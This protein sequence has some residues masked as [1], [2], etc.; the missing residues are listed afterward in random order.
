MRV[1][2]VKQRQLITAG[3]RKAKEYS[4]LLKAVADETGVS[5]QYVWQVAHGQRCSK[6]I[7]R[8]LV[9]NILRIER[10]YVIK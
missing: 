5:R 10:E 2:P 4:R 1:Y 8:S 9:V 3:A 7:I 6:R